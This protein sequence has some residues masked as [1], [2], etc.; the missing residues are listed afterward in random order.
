MGES[1]L[2]RQREDLEALH[3]AGVQLATATELVALR[4]ILL[5]STIRLT[6]AGRAVLVETDT[7][8]GVWSSV[9][10][11]MADGA[12]AESEPFDEDRSLVTES[13]ATGRS[14]VKPNPPG[15]ETTDAVSPHAAIAVPLRARNQITGALYAE[16]SYSGLGDAE[17]RMLETLALQAAPSI[18]V[19]RLREAE[20]SADR[21]VGEYISLVTHQMRIP[22][23]S[24]TG[25]TDLLLSNV[26]GTV[27]D[28]QLDFLNRIKRN[29]DR[30]NV[31][32]SDLADI[33]R[34]ESGRMK[35]E[36]VTF[37]LRDTVSS[38]ANDFRENIEGRGQCLSV[39]TSADALGVCADRSAVRRILKILLDNASRYTP[40]GGKIAVQIVQDDHYARTE[41]IDNGVGISEDDQANLITPFFRSEDSAVREHVGWG[42]G[43]VV[44]RRLAEAQ[45]G[46]I[47]WTS[48]W[49][50]GSTFAFTVPLSGEAS[51]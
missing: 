49:G 46:E 2:D 41:V 3:R 4:E 7:T 14:T 13:I 31:L 48:E 12:L 25:Y 36:L 10:E 18:E 9:T 27:S 50:E 5:E 24:V 43:L 15:D 23:T 32:V 19:F 11:R 42:L 6:G 20:T 1:W 38:V 44:A 51:G 28:R 29:V 47:T 22:L 37:D 39:D 45:G 26:A 21:E 8:T 16:N 17:L 35:L 34:L 30:M 40:H 33:N